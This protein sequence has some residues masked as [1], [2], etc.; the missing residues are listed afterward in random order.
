[1]ELR[2]VSNGSLEYVIAATVIKQLTEDKNQDNFVER[3]TYEDID[4]YL[5]FTCGEVLYEMSQRLVG[6]YNVLWMFSH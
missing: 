3:I 1:M 4:K 6:S 2:G 5:P